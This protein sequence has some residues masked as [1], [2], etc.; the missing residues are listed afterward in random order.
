MSSEEVYINPNETLRFTKDNDSYDVEMLPKHELYKAVKDR[1]GGKVEDPKC[2]DSNSWITSGVYVSKDSR[3]HNTQIYSKAEGILNI[4]SLRV[5][6]SSTLV[7]CVI[8]AGEHFY[9]RIR[10]CN[11][12]SLNVMGVSEEFTTGIELGSVNMI[13]SMSISSIGGRLIRMVNVDASGVLR[14]NLA[15]NDGSIVEITDSIFNGN[16]I[17]DI[18]AP[19]WNEHVHIKDCGF[20]GN[21]IVDV[22]E[23]LE[24]LWQGSK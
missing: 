21:L 2:L 10:L 13:G 17:L 8:I 23:N 16:I 1:F 14:I 19:D 5:T 9:N 7:D 22:K 15:R 6:D 20:A 18:D 4:G 11:L 12:S 24:K 3:L